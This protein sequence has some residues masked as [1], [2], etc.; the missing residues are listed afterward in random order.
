MDTEGTS[1]VVSVNGLTGIIVLAA[2]DISFSSVNGISA[3]LV[4]NALDELKAAIDD[5]TGYNTISET[6][7]DDDS[8]YV[9]VGDKTENNTVVISG[10]LVCGTVRTQTKIILTHDGTDIKDIEFETQPYESIFDGVFDSA[11]SGNDIR[12]T[13]ALSSKGNDIVLNGKIEKY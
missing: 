3:T 11:L 6:F 7:S 4:G 10:S 12:L 9:L 5:L 13:W 1:A 8:G 2:N